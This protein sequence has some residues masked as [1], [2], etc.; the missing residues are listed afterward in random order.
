MGSGVTRAE[1]GGSGALAARPV[2]GW[3][4]KSDTAAAH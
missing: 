2:K 4:S 3:G 1:R